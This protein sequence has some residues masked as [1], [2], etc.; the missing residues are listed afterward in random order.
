[1]KKHIYNNIIL[2]HPFHGNY[3]GMLQAGAL[4]YAVSEKHSETSI[5]C[6]TPPLTPST[7]FGYIKLFVRRLQF[8]LAS[9]LFDVRGHSSSRMR[10]AEAFQKFLPFHPL[11]EQQQNVVNA[12]D[13]NRWIVGSD[14]VWRAQYTRG[15]KSVPF[16]FLDFL[17]EE[18]R[19]Q[20]ISYAASFGT[21]EWEGTLEETQECRRLLQ[22]FKAVSVR[23]HSGV[24]I[25]REVFGVDAVQ[26]PDPT[27]LVEEGG[28]QHIIDSEKT[29]QRKEPYIAAYV[30]DEATA[31]L[32]ALYSVSDKLNL[33][34]QHLM[35]HANAK[36]LRDRFPLSVPQWLR[37]M[38]ESSFVVT[39]SFHGCVF[40]IIFN[41]PFVCLGN[42]GRGSARFDTLFQTFHLES[43]LATSPEQALVI[44]QEPIDWVAVNAIHENE[45]A[46]GLAFLKENLS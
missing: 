6:Y 39:D 18:V 29:Y 10:Y 13:E 22:Q 11:H 9:L 46:R 35:P 27:L 41:K 37:Y 31:S 15:M 20:S 45:R 1:M 28:Y 38:K 42:E 16:Y 17:P 2:T 36:L 25:C 3:G 32:R 30:L 21:D 34:I 33:P 44:A 23:E 7:I 19:R 26:M 8:S 43:R 12:P 4:W 5:G 40:A 14:Q 24:K